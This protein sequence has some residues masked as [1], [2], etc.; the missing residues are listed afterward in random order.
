VATSSPS[1]APFAPESPTSSL[2]PP[3]PAAEKKLL[4]TRRRIIRWS[5]ALLILICAGVSLR[6]AADS[7][8][9]ALSV[10]VR[11]SKPEAT[12]FPTRFA[13]HPFKEQ[14]GTLE[15]PQGPLRYRMY[16]P[17]DAAHPPGL[18]L[19]HGIH[20]AG[21][22]EPRLINFG[23][24]LAGAGIEVITP[25]LADLADYRVSPRTIDTIGQAAHA[26]CA[27]MNQPRVGVAGVSFA[28][29]LALL[30]ADRPEYG[31]NIGLVLAVGAH[32]DMARVAHFFA[33]N[34]IEKPD[35]SSVTFQ[36]HEYG[37][38]VLA[39]SHLEDFF[40]PRDVP[41]ARDALHAQ[42]WEQGDAQQK[43]DLLSPSGRQTFDKLL[44]HRDLLQQTFFREI[45][46]HRDEM[47][48]VSPHSHIS[49][50]RVPVYLL[51]GTTDSVIPASETLWLAKEV[52]P[53]ELRV[54]LISPAMNLIHVDG[55]RSVTIMQ[56]WALVDFMAQVLRAE[57]KLAKQRK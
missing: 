50:L 38:L 22:D 53:A 46:L 32:D 7:H 26:L 8:L 17:V 48:A 34:M 54:V 44:H 56:E 40:S 42:L 25:E 18:V 31:A 30:A 27:K 6:Y 3:R 9:R 43:V 21:I 57:D 47:E 11:L 23:R 19:L 49:D 20:R 45:E 5:A 2:A 51:H 24:T 13:S 37:V 35:G 55:Q 39:Y 29:G 10:L 14:E 4:R 36:A 41:L 33:A 16:I 15:T 52:P 12:G 28:G 1:S